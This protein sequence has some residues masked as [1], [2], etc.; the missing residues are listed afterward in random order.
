MSDVASIPASQG[1]HTGRPELL[2]PA[3]A[4]RIAIAAQGFTGRRRGAA[5]ASPRTLQALAARLG[6]VQIDSVN[7]VCRS[8]YLPFHSRLGAYRREDLDR[9]TTG[10][11]ASLVE[12]WA[13]EASLLPAAT[14]PLLRWR[15]QRAHLDA[16]GGVRAAGRDLPEVVEAVCRVV[17]EHGPCTATRIEAHLAPDRGPRGTSWGWNWSDVKRC[18]EFAFWAGRITSSG[19]SA[20]FERR[21]DLPERVLPAGSARAAVPPERDAVRSLVEI[22]ARACGVADLAALRDYF[23]LSPDQTRTAVD[24]LVEAGRLVPVL[25]GPHPLASSRGAVRAYLHAD[26]ALPGRV[27]AR[28]L[29]SPFDSLIWHRPRTEHLFGMRYRLEIYVPAE[30]RVHGYYVLPFLLGEE[31]VARVDLKADRTAGTDGLLRVRAAWRQPPRPGRRRAIDVPG[32]LAQ[33]LRLTADWLGL[34]DVVV[35]PKGDLAVP[36]AAAVRGDA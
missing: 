4:A 5:V 24:E 10:P 22:A 30:R 6:V 11:G 7:V 15:M 33:Q 2:S 3:A 32:E 8:H 28:A 14:H 25:V 19:R 27:A 16:W 12:Y 31:L 21:Y 26:A 36:L 9:L 20:A 17:A 29:L 34:G 18:V 23:R 13:H 1:H 35:E